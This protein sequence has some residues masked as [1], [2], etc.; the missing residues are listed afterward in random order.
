MS[1]LRRHSRF[2]SANHRGASRAADSKPVALVEPRV[3]G[4]LRNVAALET[5]VSSFK[6]TQCNARSVRPRCALRCW[7]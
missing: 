4:A 3:A 1:F 5:S 2:V 7:S 6:R